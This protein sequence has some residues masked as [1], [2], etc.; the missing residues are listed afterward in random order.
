MFLGVFSEKSNSKPLDDGKRT[1]QR[2]D[3]RDSFRG[4]DA[5]EIV[6][7][8]FSAAYDFSTG[9]EKP[10]WQI[11]GSRL[12]VFFVIPTVILVH[13]MVLW[14]NSNY[15]MIY[16]PFYSTRMRKISRILLGAFCYGAFLTIMVFYT[17]MG[18]VRNENFRLQKEVK[19]HEKYQKALN[20]KLKK[21][22]D[23]SHQI[24]VRYPL[25]S[26]VDKDLTRFSEYAYRRGT[27]QA[28][29]HS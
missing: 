27:L 29:A 8:A 14:Y 2:R 25:D 28:S 13:I 3:G 4:M 11:V 15:A 10:T 1:D 5:K 23:A 6:K 24:H 17:Y 12:L 9:K 21:F 7:N 18:S 26:L 22:R 20:D 19:E 16:I